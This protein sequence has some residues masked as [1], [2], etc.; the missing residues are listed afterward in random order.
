MINTPQATAANDASLQQR[1]ERA[2]A[3]LDER[4]ERSAAHARACMAGLRKPA[5]LSVIA[6]AAVGLGFFVARLRRGRAAVSRSVPPAGPPSLM[7]LIMDALALAAAVLALMK[8][9]RRSSDV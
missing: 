2:S 7:V 9:D 1:I 8:P 5:V 3:R 6:L 4:R